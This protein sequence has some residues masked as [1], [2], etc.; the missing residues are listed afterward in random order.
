MTLIDRNIK[1]I[2]KIALLAN[3]RCSRSVVVDPKFDSLFLPFF[4]V[5]TDLCILF[6]TNQFPL[7]VS[8][9]ALIIF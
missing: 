4:K 7:N 3:Q 1:N 2:F 6:L 8:K 9:D 5:V